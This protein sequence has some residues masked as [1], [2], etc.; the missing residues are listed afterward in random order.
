MASLSTDT[1]VRTLALTELTGVPLPPKPVPHRDAI[2]IEVKGIEQIM[3]RIKAEG[4]TVVPPKPS[5]TPEGLTFIE[6]AFED[7]DGHLI[8]LYEIRSS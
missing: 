1:A 3:E 7:F 5:K 8:V 2:V 6:Q 4:L